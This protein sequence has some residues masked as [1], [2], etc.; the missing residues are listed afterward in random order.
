MSCRGLCPH[1]KTGVPRF[2]S[3][4]P[5]RAA[6]VP[7]RSAPPEAAVAIRAVMVVS[8]ATPATVP[9]SDGPA[10]SVARRSRKPWP[11]RPCA[12]KPSGRSPPSTAFANSAASGCRSTK[13]SAACVRW[14]SKILPRGK[15]T[16]AAIQ[17]EVVQEIEQ[18]LEVILRSLRKTGRL[19]GEAVE[20]ATRAAMSRAGAAP[21]S[22]LLRA[23]QPAFQR[24]GLFVGSGVIEAGRKTIIGQRLTQSGMFWT[25]AA[26][27]QIMA[28][29]RNRLS[30]RFEDY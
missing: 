6:C 10:K 1:W 26:A 14:K 11:R 21:L 23:G 9:T 20:M 17:Q 12:E 7:V 2:S 27:N 29:R 13:R 4:L 22:E 16:A 15:K 28:L 18:L 5:S 19:H 25:V 24:P 8:P 3:G 30:D